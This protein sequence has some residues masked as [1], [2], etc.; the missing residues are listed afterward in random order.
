V[1][2]SVVCRNEHF[3][4]GL[5]IKAVALRLP[6]DSIRYEVFSR[7]YV[8]SVHVGEVLKLSLVFCRL[9]SLPECDFFALHTLAY[10]FLRTAFDM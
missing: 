1:L 6:E 2:T 9:S 7:Y 5:D 3:G 10:D 8:S 4:Q